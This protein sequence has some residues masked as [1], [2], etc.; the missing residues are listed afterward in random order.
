MN[1]NLY[2]LIVTTVPSNEL[3]LIC[4]QKNQDAPK[5]FRIS[6]PYIVCEAV[7][8]NKRSYDVN[9]M[10]KAIKEYK[11]EFIDRKT[12]LGELNHN[13]STQVDLA[14]SCHIV[15]SLVQD[16]NSFIGTSRV[17][18]GTVKGDLFLGLLLNEVR[19]G[20]SSRG[21]GKSNAQGKVDDYKL[22]AVDAVANPSAPGAYIDGI[23]ESKNFMLNEHRQIVEIAYQNLENRISKLPGREDEKKQ[24]LVEAIKQFLKEI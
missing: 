18:T 9:V 13:P 12:A 11:E 1:E 24:L 22:V 21:V 10:I 6:C 15:E 16:G 19:V 3:K 14:N 5:V 17:L 7:N 23:L 20:M 4:E 2:K 8:G